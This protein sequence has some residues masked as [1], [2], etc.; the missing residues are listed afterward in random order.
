LQQFTAKSD[1]HE[2]K[3]DGIKED[4]EKQIEIAMTDKET[5]MLRMKLSHPSSG[6]RFSRE[7]VAPVSDPQLRPDWT[8]LC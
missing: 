7:K 5:C 8:T 2:T 1:S 4:G 3:L 6:S